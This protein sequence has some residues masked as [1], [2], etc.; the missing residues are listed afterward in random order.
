MEEKKERVKKYKFIGRP[1]G[2]KAE[3][4]RTKHPIIGWIYEDQLTEKMVSNL[5]L[6]DEKNGIEFCNCIK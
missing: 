1:K 4:V 2:A 5:K 6:I 3:D